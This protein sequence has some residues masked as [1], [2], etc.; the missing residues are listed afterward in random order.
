MV[1]IAIVMSIVMGMIVLLAASGV[2]FILGLA[3]GIKR[4]Q[5][6]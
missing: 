1:A 6:N 5:E 3:Y 2:A 4:S